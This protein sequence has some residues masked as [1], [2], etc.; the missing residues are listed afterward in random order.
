MMLM[1]VEKKKK[2]KMVEVDCS[3]VV[4]DWKGENREDVCC[5]S[6]LQDP[7]MRST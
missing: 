2:K 4:A 5:S 1:E 7:K 3:V 6:L